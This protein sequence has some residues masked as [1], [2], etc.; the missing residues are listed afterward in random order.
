MEQIIIQVKDKFKAKML[1]ELLN[2]MNFV[3]DIKIFKQ[4]TDTNQKIDFFSFAGMWADRD[5]SL[6]SIRQKAWPGQSL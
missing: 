3:S 5:V 1:V 6:K 4:H 2:D